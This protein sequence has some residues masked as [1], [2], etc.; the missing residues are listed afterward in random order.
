MTSQAYGNTGWIT[1]EIP[2]GYF[3]TTSRLPYSPE[4]DF[5]QEEEAVE[6][7]DDVKF[8]WEGTHQRQQDDDDDDDDDEPITVLKPE[9]THEFTTFG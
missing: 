7:G 6:D 8:M 2:R 5:V 9:Y 3:N 1:L 4:E